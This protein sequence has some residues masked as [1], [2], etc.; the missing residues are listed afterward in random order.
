MAGGKFNAQQIK[1]TQRRNKALELRKTGASYRQIADMLRSNEEIG[2]TS[3]YSR[4]CA[5]A[6]VREALKEAREQT[7]E[8]ATELREIEVQRLDMASVAI[9]KMVR[10]GN[11]GAIDRWIKIIESRCRLL[12]LNVND[13]DKAWTTLEA[14]G[15]QRVDDGNGGYTLVDKYTKNNISDLEKDQD[16][17][18][19]KTD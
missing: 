10:D 16:S 9:A 13:L 17:S 3:R 5:Y 19:M 12:G 18:D 1:I 2:T 11:L 6:D 8:T 4:F 14:Y 15:F 7:Q